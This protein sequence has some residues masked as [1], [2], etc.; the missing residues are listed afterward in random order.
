MKHDDFRKPTT[1]GR[2]EP[3]TFNE[4]HFGP[5]GVEL[6]AVDGVGYVPDDLPAQVEST[7][8]AAPIQDVLL[9]A[10]RNLSLLEGLAANLENPALLIGPFARKEA[11]H[12]SAIENTFAS[13]NQ[14]ALFDLDPTTIDAPSRP[15]V[16]EVNNY[17]KALHFGYHADM[18]ICLRLMRDMH[19]ILLDGVSRS[20]G[21][22][23]EFR[24]TQNAIGDQT[25]PFSEAKFVPPP[26]RFLNHCL[27]QLEQFIHAE[28]NLPRLVRFA[29]IHY[30]FECI[31]PFDDGNGR[32]GRLLIALQLCEQAQLSLPLVY[33]SGFFERNRGDYYSLLYRVSSEGAWLDWIKFFLSAVST[34]ANDAHRRAQKLLALR[35]NYQAAV[36]QKRASAMLPKVVDELFN[37]PAITIARVAQVASMRPPSAGKLVKQLEDLGIIHEATGRARRRVYLASDIINV[38]EEVMEEP[39]DPD[40]GSNFN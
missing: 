19:K 20:V 33:V 18:P 37:H 8:I 28:S 22:P 27:Q 30:Q 24:T 17:I 40:S 26:P 36:Q 32:L 10:E 2:L 29:L 31:H 15:E 14:L 23:G 35:S 5:K 6:R 21:R 38:M 16:K 13:A 9:S 7:A 11:K 25:A 34:Q 1:P 3:T 4:R 12:S 39:D